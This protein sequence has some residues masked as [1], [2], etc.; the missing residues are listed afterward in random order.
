MTLHLI[1]HDRRFAVEQA[2]LNY[3]PH[4][5]GGEAAVKLDPSGRLA[6]VKIEYGGKTAY[7]RAYVT[8][9]RSVDNTLRLAFY[10]AAKQVLAPPPWGALTG[11]RPVKKAVELLDSGE[12]VFSGLQKHYDVSA[13]RARMAADCAA[14]TANWRKRLGKRDIAVYVAIPFCPTR[15]AY[16]S[17]V[18]QSVERDKGMMERYTEVLKKEIVSM[19]ETVSRSGLR[20]RAVYWGGGTPAV[21]PSEM[22]CDLADTLDKHLDLSGV[23]EYT[24]EAGRP[25]AITPQKLEA[26]R[27]SGAGRVSVN[28]QTLRQEVLDAIGRRH[29]PDDF[30]KAYEQ[31]RSAGFHVVNTDLI[32]GLPADNPDGFLRGMDE[33]LRLNPENIT[34]HTLAKKRSSHLNDG[35]T[36]VCTADGVAAMLDGAGMRLRSAGYAP[37]YLY[38]QKFSEGGFENTG[39]TKPGHECLYNLCMMEE[40][41]TVLSLGAGGVSKIV[42]GSLIERVFHCKYPLDYVAGCDI[43]ENIYDKIGGAL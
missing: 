15:C 16:C 28:P 18:S 35:Q 26:Y 12:D 2:V 3:F 36:A 13:E 9:S 19:A 34:V 23:I 29:T 32:A 10:R 5:D 40:L 30:F 14:H 37:Y 4:R 17:F 33:I 25:D 21:L 31:A 24:V 42:T 39:W 27:K 7:G 8:G 43:L 11:V 41:T 22:Y 6:S 38:R 20:V 1:N